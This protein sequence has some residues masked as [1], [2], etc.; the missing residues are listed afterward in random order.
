MTEDWADLRA[1]A[2][3]DGTAV[4]WP[5]RL[6][7]AL[8][9]A[10]LAGAGVAAAF[11]GAVWVAA[12]GPPERLGEAL[13]F[14]VSLGLVV[15]LAALIPRASQGDL[16]ALGPEVTVPAALRARLRAALLCHDGRDVGVNAVVGAAI[17]AA[18]VAFAG[19]GWPAAPEEWVLAGGTV[20]LWAMMVQTGALLVANARL[21]AQ[22]GRSAVRVEVLSPHRL[23][24]FASAALRPMLLIMA[25]LAAYPL[26]LLGA[27]GLGPASAVGA[28]ATVALA[29]AA[30]WL[31]LR[32]LAARIRAARDERLDGLDAAIAAAAADPHAAP[33]D[34]ACLEALLALR[35]RVQAV[36]VLPLGLGGLGRALV[37]LALPLATWGGKGFAEAVLSRL[38]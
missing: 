34:P 32:G 28:V 23:R 27:G 14:A 13:F 24:P 1:L 25:L 37:Y 20:A 29:L 8:G 6:R 2:V 21:F 5:V 12:G 9:L 4:F 30:V 15:E 22:L 26:M 18:H 16:D 3:R 36:P 10:G 38:F 19:P 31:P 35:A 33:S 7:A 17:G 11:L